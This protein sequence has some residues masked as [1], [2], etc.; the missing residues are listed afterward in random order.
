MISS[1]VA[2]RI[3]S[4]L[5]VVEEVE[6]RRCQEEQN[7]F[8]RVRVAL[9]ITKPL[10]HGAYIAGT[11]RE[12]MWVTFKYE[13]L[14]IF[15]HFCGLLGHDVQHYA[16]HYAAEKG[17]GEVEYQYGDWLKASGSHPRTSQKHDMNHTH[18]VNEGTMDEQNSVMAVPA[19]TAEITRTNPKESINDVNEGSEILGS[20][21][22]NQLPNHENNGIKGTLNGD[23]IHE[24]ETDGS[25]TLLRTREEVSATKKDIMDVHEHGSIGPTTSKPKSTWVRLIHMECGP[26]GINRAPNTQSLGKR[27]STQ[28]PYEEA[29]EQSTKKGKV[30]ETA[31]LSNVLSAG[32]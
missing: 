12:R 17:N 10:R 8:I 9:P 15:C 5:G 6:K 19:M 18:N 2:T 16:G 26:S 24:T 29:N 1:I 11:D 31:A 25:S 4:R 23:V 32:V 22:T 20:G 30:E 28:G 14:P 27:N 3:G 13:R 7:L 21:P